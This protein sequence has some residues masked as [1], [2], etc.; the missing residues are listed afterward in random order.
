MRG[1]TLADMPPPLFDTWIHPHGL[2]DQDLA[3]LAFFGVEGAVAV[4]GY[5]LPGADADEWLAW[6][7]SWV[8]GQPGR[9]RTR[10]IAPFL[11]VG[12]HPRQLPQR[13]LE[14]V[15]ASLPPL[16]DEARIVAIGAIGLDRGGPGEERAFALQLELAKDLGTRVMV[17]TPE[18][19]K[20]KW[21]RRILNL[22]LE[23]GIEADRIL[24]GQVDARTIRL[25]RA[26]GY[27][28]CL[29]VSPMRI[30]AEDAVEMIR[31]MGSSGLLLASD[32]GAGPGDLLALP[33]TVHLLERAGLSREILDR[34]CRT[35]ALSFFGIDPG[36][37]GSTT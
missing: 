26:C 23:S 22:L 17:H 32:A 8:R 9:M 34:V 2:P 14:R 16:F 19:D 36:T 27:A 37:L 25:I 35:N 30:R 18:R 24:V 15:I 31:Q 12:L 33:R 7:R 28:A 5:D 21:T 3:D 4:T 20:P 6:L 11:A 1:D 13:G 10:G 29:S